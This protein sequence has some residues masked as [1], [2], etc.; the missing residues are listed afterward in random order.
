MVLSQLLWKE[1]KSHDLPEGPLSVRVTTCTS[2]FY[3]LE[4]EEKKYTYISK[5]VGYLYNWILFTCIGK[6]IDLGMSLRH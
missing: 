2:K 1:L 5:F 4:E 6:K 3:L